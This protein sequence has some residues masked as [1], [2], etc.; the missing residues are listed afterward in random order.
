[1]HHKNKGGELIPRY[2]WY[3][4][5]ALLLLLLIDKTRVFVHQHIRVFTPAPDCGFS[6]CSQECH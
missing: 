2:Q 6:I 1:M 5:I 3:V 4:L